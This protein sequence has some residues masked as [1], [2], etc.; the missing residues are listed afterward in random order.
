MPL[1]TVGI[2]T[3][4]S[5]AHVEECLAAVR[6]Q[7]HPDVEVRIADN[8]SRDGTRPLLERLTAP[9]QRL[10]LER[11]TGFA[12]G[13]NRLIAS[14]RGDFYLALNP[15]VV[16]GP[17]YVARLVEACRVASR[18]GSATGKL[19]RRD[20]PGVIDSTGI[21][22]LPSMR[23]LDRG[24]EEPDRGQ[25]D[26]RLDVF[27]ASGAAALYARAMLDDTR[28]GQEWFDED[29]FA[30]RE[31]ADLAWRAQLLGWGCQYVPAAVAVHVR[32]VTPERRRDLPPEVNRWSV[33]NRFL[34]RLK[35]QTLRH[36]VTF[37]WPALARDLQV[38]GYV[39]LRER[40]S[41]AGLADVLRLLPRMLRKRRQIMARRRATGAEMARW[42][43]GDPL[44]PS[45]RTISGR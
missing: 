21:V 42:F 7:T 40:A 11:N 28:V 13:H 10:F 26:Q 37:A 12:A 8:D 32:R 43:R 22:M 35:N 45:G 2:V 9:E 23:H 18:V 20:P 15:D 36:A 1:V 29:F 33:R 5:A 41:L 34:L 16:L 44:S 3:W 24:A 4:H 19:L 39:L 17:D 25:Y 14:S 6:A 27:G 31:D 38:V 30:Y